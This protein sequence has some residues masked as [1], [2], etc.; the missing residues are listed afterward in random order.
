MSGPKYD[1]W[2][3]KLTKKY[4]SLDQAGAYFSPYKYHQVLRKQGIRIPFNVVKDKI[5][6]IQSYALHRKVNYKFRKSKNI[7]QGYLYQLDVDLADLSNISQYNDNYR[8]LLIAI[9]TFSR[10]LFVQP[11][12]D[13]KGH[14]VLQAFK[15]I[16]TNIPNNAVKKIRSDSGTEFINKEVKQYF[17]S[18]SIDSFTSTNENKASFAE[19]VIRTLKMIM[20]RYF[21]QNNTKRY[22]DDL[23]SFV[24]NY[25]NTPH[26]SIFNMTP[27]EVN[28]KNQNT[29]WKKLYLDTAIK[30]SKPKFKFKIGQIVRISH[31]RRTFSKDSQVRWTRE[32]FKI[33]SCYIR[34][35][36]PIYTLKDFAGERIS[37][38]FYENELQIANYKKSDTFLIDEIIKQKSIKGKKYSLVSYLGWPN[39]YNEWIPN[40][41]LLTLPVK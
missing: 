35:G 18:K 28:F 15:K 24:Y 19:R 31:N 27:A 41:S 32:L 11:L 21:T 23:Q 30:R 12:K 1:K 13:K 8:Y 37:G 6:A 20:T 14:T 16:L 9:C 36:T 38:N 34:Q 26:R 22:I 2:T 39:K 5:E 17:K 10:Q 29:L 4:L 3:P 7:S 25:N 33:T 40:S